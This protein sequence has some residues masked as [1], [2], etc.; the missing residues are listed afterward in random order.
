MPCLIGRVAD[1]HSAVFVAPRCRLARAA[2]YSPWPWTKQLFLCGTSLR[3]SCLFSAVFVRHCAVSFAVVAESNNRYPLLVCMCFYTLQT[4][5]FNQLTYFHSC[6]GFTDASWMPV[7]F[8]EVDC[9]TVGNEGLITI[10]TLRDFRFRREV[11]ENCSLLDC[12]IT[13]GGYF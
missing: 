2:Q 7:G 12:Y 10:V 13:S 11:D 3:Y 9:H 4:F 1:V 6:S 8:R 5:F